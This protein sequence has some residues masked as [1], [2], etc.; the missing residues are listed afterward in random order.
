MGDA[1]DATH[2]LIV[3]AHLVENEEEGVVGGL[4]GVFLLD[5]T[6]SRE[7]DGLIVVDEAF[8][9][10]I[11]PARGGTVLP[12]FVVKQFTFDEAGRLLFHQFT[13]FVVKFFY[14]FCDISIVLLALQLGNFADIVGNEHLPG[15]R[16]ILFS[17]IF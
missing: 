16:N 4:G 3:H 7:V 2:G 17:R 6:I 15:D 8:V 5:T 1:H 14:L 9:V 13:N 10:I 11:R 12:D